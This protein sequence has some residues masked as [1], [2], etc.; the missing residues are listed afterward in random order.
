MIEKSERRLDTLAE[1]LE[2]D[3]MCVAVACVEG[4]FVIAANEFHPGTHKTEGHYNLIVEIMDYFKDIA[5]TG[6]EPE[7]TKKNDLLQKIY[8]RRFAHKDFSKF[9]PKKDINSGEDNE[10]ELIVNSITIQK[11]AQ[12]FDGKKENF[13]NNQT[14][15]L[16]ASLAHQEMTKIYDD[17][18][19]LEKAIIKKKNYP[20][21]LE[22]SITT[23]QFN[24]VKN[25]NANNSLLLQEKS[26]NEQRKQKANQARELEIKKEETAKKEDPLYSTHAEMQLLSYIIDKMQRLEESKSIYLGISKK[27]CPDCACML[28]A[29]NTFLAEESKQLS[30]KYGQSHEGDF[31]KSWFFPDSFWLPKQE[32]LFAKIKQKYFDD[33]KIFK[34]THTKEKY[35]QSR[36]YSDSEASED[37]GV[38]IH[39]YHAHLLSKQ[40][41]L[42]EVL[43]FSNNKQITSEECQLIIGVGIF[44]SANKLLDDFFALSDEVNESELESVAENFIISLKEYSI[45]PIHLKLFLES[46]YFPKVPQKDLLCKLLIAKM[47]ETQPTS[48]VVKDQQQYS[49]SEKSSLEISDVGD[50][51]SKSSSV[52]YQDYRPY[53]SKEDQQ[54]WKEQEQRSG[55][56][57]TLEYSDRSD[58]E[59][60]KDETLDLQP[61]KREIDQ[62]VSTLI[63]KEPIK[64]RRK[65]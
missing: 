27:C 22:H 11:L 48:H 8:L 12:N 1:I 23:A 37:L 57:D 21:S 6:Q 20:D 7:D 10:L 39:Q 36:L 59:S 52:S 50:E 40:K 35:Y 49:A 17:L 4:E 31:G 61:E 51:S 58:G 5:T 46:P 54:H 64:K 9:R 28:R 56:L 53:G 47:A 44:L 42:A 55:L 3:S 30:I 60:S 63:D 25:F 41:H 62:A 2:C 33:I 45:N 43:D 24:A 14:I 15:C 34:D 19:K 18:R 13:G 38:K 65:I 26:K 29:A 16:K 32:S